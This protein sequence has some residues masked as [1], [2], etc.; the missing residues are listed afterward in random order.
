MADKEQSNNGRVCHRFYS[1]LSYERSQAESADCFYKEILAADVV[2]RYNH[3]T[4]EDMVWQHRDIDATITIKGRTFHVSEKFRNRA[5]SDLLIEIY[6]QYPQTPGW[7]RTGVPDIVAYF[8]PDEVCIVREEY[9]KPFVLQ[10]FKAIPQAV[11]DDF[12][13]SGQLQ[14]K[15][16]IQLAEK[17]SVT[18]ISAA[19]DGYVTISVA[20]PFGVLDANGVKYKTFG[21][22]VAENC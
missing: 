16:N 22:R 14:K 11:V 4:P 10:L 6:S 1:S 5:W 3:D 18:L 21:R 12:Y 13:Q 2:K 15:I 8:F 9:L 19:N 17:C 20:V 7:A